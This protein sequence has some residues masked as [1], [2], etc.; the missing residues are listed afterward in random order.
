M[1]SYFC[2][3]K[4]LKIFLIFIKLFLKFYLIESEE[5]N[6]ISFDNFVKLA[7]ESYNTNDLNHQLCTKLLKLFDENN[8][9]TFDFNEF[10]KFYKFLNEVFPLLFSSENLKDDFDKIDLNNDGNISFEGIFK[11]FII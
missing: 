3:Y 5:K 8:N 6:S 10:E 2:S 11:L 7:K 1:L 9:G 4:L